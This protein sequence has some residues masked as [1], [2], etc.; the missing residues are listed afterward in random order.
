MYVDDRRHTEAE[1]IF[2]D[3]LKCTDGEPHIVDE[4]QKL[5]DEAVAKQSE[6]VGTDSTCGKRGIVYAKVEGH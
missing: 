3:G 2:R 6:S 1:Q 5:L 4:L